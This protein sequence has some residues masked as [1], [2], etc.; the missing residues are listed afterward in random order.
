MD[1]EVDRYATSFWDEIEG[2]WKCE[3]GFYD[4]LVGFS[5]QEILGRGE[6][7]VGKTSYWSGL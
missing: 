1:I 7:V 2:M 6:L 4:V 3:E 5:S